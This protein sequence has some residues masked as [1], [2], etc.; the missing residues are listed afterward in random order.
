MVPSSWAKHRPGAVGEHLLRYWGEVGGGGLGAFQ[1]SLAR[2][3]KASGF[4]SWNVELKVEALRRGRTSSRR[5]SSSS[6]S[7]K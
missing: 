1:G 3:F 2:D 4:G 6:S 7:S 5:R